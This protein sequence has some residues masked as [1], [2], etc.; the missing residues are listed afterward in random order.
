MTPQNNLE[1]KGKF[2]DFP[3]AELLVEIAE[4]QLNGSLRFSHE[5]RKI[6]AYFRKGEL[7]YAISNARSA[8][9]FDILLREKKID[10]K[11]LLQIPNFTGDLELGMALVADGS[12]TKQEID[13]FFSTQIEEI[14][15]ESLIWE[16][17]EWNFNPLAQIREGIDFKTNLRQLLAEYSRN[18]SGEAV[19]KRFRS[20]QESFSA[21]DLM[22]ATINLNPHEAF[23]LS[24]FSGMEMTIEEVKTV[25]SLPDAAVFQTLYTLWLGGFV[26]RKHWNSAFSERHISQIKSANL[27]L[28]KTASVPSETR[29]ETKFEPPK[30]T[31]EDFAQPDSEVP[32]TVEEEKISLEE[33]LTQVENAANHYEVLGVGLKA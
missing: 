19:F 1:L 11:R 8:R 13:A 9:L 33:Y 25:S 15:R 16:T 23:I 20:L 30:P 7:V 28:V 4:A 2:A 31:A 3:L 27:M 26:I 6:A 32:A 22:E 17:G 12:F 21:K 29:P 18:L 5:D 14:L 10:K 24:R